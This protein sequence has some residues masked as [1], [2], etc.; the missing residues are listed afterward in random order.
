MLRYDPTKRPSAAECLQHPYF[1]VRLPIPL[2]VASGE[3]EEEIKKPTEDKSQ[4]LE[5]SSQLNELKRAEENINRP[6]RIKITSK[7]LMQ[8]A[9]YRPGVKPLAAL[10][11]N[12]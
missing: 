2:S 6:R 12:P 10:K 4:D 9:R 7:E 8:N 11:N 1:Q 5:D 3:K